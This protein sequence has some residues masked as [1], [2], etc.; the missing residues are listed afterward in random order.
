MEVRQFSADR[1]TLI[2]NGH[3]GRSPTFSTTALASGVLPSGRRFSRSSPSTPAAA[4]RSCQRHTVALAPAHLTHD[5]QGADA[6]GGQEHDPR[7]SDMLLTTVAIRHDRLEP[8]S[9][10]CHGWDRIRAGDRAWS[11]SLPR[12]GSRVAADPK[13]AQTSYAKTR[14]GVARKLAIIEQGT[15]A[16][17]EIREQLSQFV[18]ILGLELGTPSPTE[19]PR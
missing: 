4:N 3:R 5:R 14:Q 11:R 13:D 8:S 17:A 18:A 12:V 6:V 2:P 16:I 19:R 15:E 1:K 10:P 9:T 7:P